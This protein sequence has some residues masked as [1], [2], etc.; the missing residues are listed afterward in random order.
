MNRYGAWQRGCSSGWPHRSAAARFHHTLAARAAHSAFASASLPGIGVGQWARTATGPFARDELLR[1]LEAILFLAQEPLSSRK[2]ARLAGLADGTQARTLVRKLNRLYDA[3]G[4]AFRVE[5]VAGGFQLMSRPKFAPWLRRLQPTPVELRL[6]PPALETLAVVAY[7]QPVLRAEIES[8]RGVQCD[9]VLRQLIERDLVRVVGRSEQ[10]GRPF[11]YGTS[12]RFLQVFGLRHLDELPRPQSWPVAGEESAAARARETGQVAITNLLSKQQEDPVNTNL[13]AHV[14][15]L[16]FAVSSSGTP[17]GSPTV[18]PC[19]GEQHADPVATEDDEKSHFGDAE[20]EEDE[21]DY[22]DEFAEE[23]EED[24]EE[25]EEQFEDEDW[26]G[27]WEEVED[28]DW[29]EEEEEEEEE[30][31]EDYEDEEDFDDEDFD[32]DEEEEEEDYDEFDEEED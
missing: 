13:K 8:V 4:W 5:E 9:E 23:E 14:G 7:R 20:L 19:C 10:L 12:K 25:E 27:E 22:D 30:D 2:L 3:G 24:E 21:E 28:E 6:S 18:A 16:S 32:E 11:L 31:E 1:R 15:E 17:P 26:E 29:D